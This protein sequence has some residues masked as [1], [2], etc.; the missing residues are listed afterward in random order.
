MS[1]ELTG[2][3]AAPFH[4]TRNK[5]GVGLTLLPATGRLR[6]KDQ[7]QGLLGLQCIYGQPEQF[8]E[9]SY[10]KIKNR[11]VGE[12]WRSLAV[13]CLSYIAC[14]RPWAQFKYLFLKLKSLEML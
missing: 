6:Q 9:R 13:E 12:G 14:V 4:S 8:S 2:R 1:V 10:L 11:K 3:Q 7:A 5:E